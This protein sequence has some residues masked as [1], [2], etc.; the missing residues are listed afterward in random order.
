MILRSI[1]SRS[2]LSLQPGDHAYLSKK[3][4]RKGLSKQEALYSGPYPVQKKIGQ[5]TYVL[6]GTPAST[7]ALQNVK[8]L[9]KFKLSPTRF[10]ERQQRIAF[11]TIENQDEWEVEKILSHRGQGLNRQYLIKWKDS[12]ENTWIP[13]KNLE[14]AKKIL[15]EYQ[16]EIGEYP[17]EEE[18]QDLQDEAK[19]NNK[20]QESNDKEE[21]SGEHEDQEV[22][23]D[24]FM[25]SDDEDL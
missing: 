13:P 23:W 24:S 21:S 11:P 8:H 16:R 18:T 19:D 5:S 22:P 10:E 9:K 17:M 15:Q 2:P 12:E 7:P 25:W 1:S 20:A 3:R 14:N 6:G 4:Q